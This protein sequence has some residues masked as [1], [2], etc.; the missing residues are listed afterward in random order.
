MAIVGYSKN[1]TKQNVNVPPTIIPEGEINARVKVYFDE[2]V[3]T[4]APSTGD[5]F[6]CLP[7]PEGARILDAAVDHASLGAAGLVALGW[8]ATAT[9]AADDDGFVVAGA[10]KNAAL[11]KKMSATAGTA[12]QFKKFADGEAAI[13]VIKFTEG[14]TNASVTYRV[15]IY[16]T[17]D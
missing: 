7:L 13:P 17:I 6:E 16:Y 12:G 11:H 3:L 10:T 8:K 14:P 2:L 5:E 15:A 1:Y 9:E 4:A